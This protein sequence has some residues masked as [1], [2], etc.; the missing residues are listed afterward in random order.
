[1]VKYR[2]VILIDFP[3]FYDPFVNCLQILRLRS[4]YQMFIKVTISE[5]RTSIKY[6][7][8][9]K[10]KYFVSKKFFDLRA[11]KSLPEIKLTVGYTIFDN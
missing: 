2:S 4:I 10:S 7:H 5:R 3:D 6:L 8:Y 11:I 9:K 1:M